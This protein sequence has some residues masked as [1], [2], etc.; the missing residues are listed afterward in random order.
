MIDLSTLTRDRD[1]GLARLD[2]T[3]A[4][5]QSE[6]LYPDVEAMRT[7]PAKTVSEAVNLLDVM[8]ERNAA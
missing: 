7:E 6:P 1:E 4:K 5:L 2:A 8:K 3:L